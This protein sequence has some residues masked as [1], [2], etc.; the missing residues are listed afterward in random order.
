LKIKKGKHTK[1]M[2]PALCALSALAAPG[3]QAADGNSFH[4]GGYVRAGASINLQDAPETPDNDRGKLSMLRGTVLIDADA[5]FGVAKVKAIARAARE[6]K[7]DYLE[8]LETRVKAATPG[9]PGS[10]LMDLYNEAELREFHVEFDPTPRLKV[11][12]GKQQVVWGETDFFRALDV[13]HGFDYRW[14]GFLEPENEELRKPLIM[15]N[16]M[17]QVPEA[18]G[19]LQF[20]FRPG[21]DRDR[22]IGNTVDLAG[23]RWRPQP[24]RGIDTLSATNF[25]YRHPEGDTEDR[26][27]G[28]R[29]SGKA[30]PVNYSLAYL[31][32]FNG[33]PVLNS[34][35][36]PYKKTPSGMLG[37][38]IHPKVEVY[39]ATLSGYAQAIDAVFSGEFALTKDAAFNVGST[40]FMPGVLPEGLGGIV[41]KDTFMTMLRMDKNLDLRDWL[42]TS[43]LSMF[44][45]QVFNTHIKDFD[46]AEDVVLNVGY[47][48]K[49]KKDAA[50]ITGILGMSYSGDRIN[51]QIAIGHDM[52]YG[53]YFVIPSVDFVMGDHWRLKVE[54]DLFY[55]GHPR[56][57]TTAFADTGTMGYFRD[58]NQLYV[59]LTR[60]F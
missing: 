23:G 8:D 20:L 57:P 55:G 58:N 18:D 37:D 39:G 50:I 33:D 45:V 49:R 42:G 14:R 36:A 52:S 10:N 53:G 13:V 21:W 48:T 43:K 19:S 54:A 11:R 6:M 27:W 59:R 26:T 38:W 4:V 22:D 30:G 35:F 31:E 16:F 46:A 44:S 2:L 24:Y 15:A 9:G 34:A 28:A 51:P 17:L 47:N 25:D 29:W 41:R 5:D 40:S 56:S 12:L 60:Q 3:V 7:T 1:R 32:T